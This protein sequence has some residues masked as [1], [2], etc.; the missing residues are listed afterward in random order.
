M[1]EKKRQQNIVNRASM[2]GNLPVEVN[3]ENNL[4]KIN[5]CKI[6]SMT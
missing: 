6:V 4:N 3:R 2:K 5:I 1:W